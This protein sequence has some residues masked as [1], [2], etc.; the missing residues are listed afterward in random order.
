MY[1]AISLNSHILIPYYAVPE[2][3]S[4]VLIIDGDDPKEITISWP[5]SSG[6]LRYILEMRQFVA[7]GPSKEK[8]KN[9]DGSPHELAGTELE[10]TVTNLSEM[11]LSATTFL[12]LP[13]L[14]VC[15][16]PPLFVCLSVCLSVSL[17]IGLQREGHHMSTH[18]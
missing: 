7:D 2:R 12:Y 9:I 16:F 11:P 5:P 14:S 6:V 3:L 4:P 10:H 15:L 17:P 8:M 13:L 1:G 18:W